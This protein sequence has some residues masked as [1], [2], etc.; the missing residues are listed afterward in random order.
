[1][2]FS[3]VFVLLLQQ[4]TFTPQAKNVFIPAKTRR[5][6]DLKAT[7]NNPN[8][9]EFKEKIEQQKIWREKKKAKKEAYFARKA[10]L[11][12]HQPIRI[13]GNH[14]DWYL[15]KMKEADPLETKTETEENQE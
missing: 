7:L 14:M 4:L 3:S 9:P 13:Y 11:R 2:F 8:N 10:E 5:E 6:N 15:Q 1:M 12:G